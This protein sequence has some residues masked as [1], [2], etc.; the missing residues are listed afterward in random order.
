MFHQ[1][2]GINQHHY[3]LSESRKLQ[4]AYV[5]LFVIS[6]NEFHPRIQSA[7]MFLVI[8]VAVYRWIRLSVECLHGSTHDRN[9]GCC[10]PVLKHLACKH[11]LQFK[12]IFNYIFYSRIQRYEPICAFAMFQAENE[13]N[14]ISLN[15]KC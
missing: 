14:G 12:I 6:V 4:S 2:V 15:M 5:G 3:T 9:S 13:Y 7:I 10:N 8:D 11:N 1:N